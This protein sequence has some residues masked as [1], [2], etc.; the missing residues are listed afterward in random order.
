M[1]S[2]EA[3]PLK[4]TWLAAPSKRFWFRQKNAKTTYRWMEVLWRRFTWL[5]LSEYICSL[6]Y[7]ANQASAFPKN[8]RALAKSKAK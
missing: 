5:N 7:K 6:C 3:F 2:V 4:L 1:P 8:L